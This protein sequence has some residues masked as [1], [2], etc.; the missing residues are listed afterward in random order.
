MTSR[1]TLRGGA[2]SGSGS[3]LWLGVFL[4]LNACGGGLQ[5]PEPGLEPRAGPV[6]PPAEPAVIALPISIS[7]GKIRSALSAQFPAGDSL[8]QAQCVSL[9]GA[10]CHQY[11]YR[12]DSLELH[13]SGD[14]IDLLARLRYRGRVALGGVAGLA[15]CGYAPESMKRA[16]LRAATA[17][18]WRN[19]WRLASRN[20]SLGVTLPDPC[21]VT[22]LKVDAT[23]LMKRIVD[24]QAERLKQQLDSV[25]PAL[26]D[27][28]PSADS[29]WR[30][31]LKPIALD[32]ASTVWLSMN[33]ENVALARP[34]GR[35]DA[36]T[37]AV[38]ITARPKAVIGAAPARDRR[39]LPTLGLAT[40]ASGIHVPVDI[41]LP[42]LSL[43]ARVTQ[44]MKGEIPE[45]NVTVDSVRIWG[46]ADT[47]V[48]RVSVRGTVNGDLFALG[49]V[50]YDSVNR[51]LL[52]SD[53]KYTLASDSR[54]SRFKATIGSYRIKRA[55]DQ[56]TGHGQ[57]DIGTQLDSLRRQLTAQL[58]RPLAP[59]VSVSGSVNDI[60]ISRLATSNTAFVLRVVLDGA[61]RLLV[62]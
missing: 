18:Y 27:L 61:A 19:D 34:L 35:G 13:M 26:A 8:T 37:T 4:V 25:I 33:P 31:L 60:R 28:R 11:V 52:V 55:L 51:H 10:V 41:E 56:A 20:T 42:F 49:R 32:S 12:R 17:L 50:Q 46:V 6:L 54:M 16:E 30:A 48:V 39:A 21:Q 40:T 5:V 14:R 2:A 45:A 38:V 36:L 59:G 53:L 23:P 15:S 1:L 3:R 58:N 43:S 47:M 29:L 9:G 22:L 57:L 44:L 62:Q 24:G 7:L